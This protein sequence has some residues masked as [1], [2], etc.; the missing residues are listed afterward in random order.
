VLCNLRQCIFKSA[1]GLGRQNDIIEGSA[2]GDGFDRTAAE[3]AKETR[4]WNRRHRYTRPRL[5]VGINSTAISSPGPHCLIDFGAICAY[6][7]E[8]RTMQAWEESIDI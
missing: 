7:A 3:S 6:D 1:A 4:E 8:E 5:P 2:R